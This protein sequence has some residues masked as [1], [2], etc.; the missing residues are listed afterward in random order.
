MH[1]DSNLNEEQKKAVYS[2]SKALLIIAGAGTGKTRVLTTRVAR[3]L[4]ENPEARYLLLTFTK[5]AAKEMTSRVRELIE[6][7]TTNRLYSGTFH[8]FCAN[9]IRRMALRVGLSNNFV[10]IDETDA[11][12]LMKKVFAKIYS[13]EALEALIFKPK[14]ILALY[15]YARNNNQ[16]LSEIIQKRYKYVNFEDIK[17]IISMYETNKKERNYLDFDDLLMYGLLVIKTLDKSPF[18]EVLVDEFQ[19]TNQIQAEMLY[20]FYKLGSRVSAVGD[21]AQSIYS[22]RGAYYENMLNFIKKLDAEKIILSS[23]YRSTQSILDIAN[24]VIQSSYSS[25]KKELVAKVNLKNNVK[26]KLII[27]PDDWE[28]ARYV[29][30]EIQK[31]SEEGLKVAVLYR[32]AYIGRNLESQLNSMGINYSFYGGQKLTESAHAKDFM[33]FLRIFVNIKD[34]IALLRILRMFPG[35]G[36]KKAEKIKDAIIAG[37]NLKDLLTKEKNLTELYHFLSKISGITD[38]HNILEVIFD[39]YKDIMKRL[40]PENY[41]EREIDLVK[42][43]DMSSNYDNLLEYL[44]AFTLDP[45]E[46]SE[47]KSSNIILSTIHSAKGLEFDVVFILSVVEDVYPHFKAQSSDEIEEERRLFYVAITRAKQR[48]IFTFPMYSKKNKSY[49]AKNIISPFLQEKNNYLDVSI[50][51]LN[52]RE[53]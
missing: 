17:K 21:D 2:D 5:K 11:M 19:D 38:W 33:S 41:E 9:I 27:V 28:E 7:D 16:D 45:V 50:V 39:F 52:P 29:A 18:D 1:L 22:F 35:I 25:I 6:E 12:D 37:G 26:P 20:Q 48:L 32:A 15:S 40:Y 8:S 49:F 47:S 53:F 44:E 31:F 43:I 13:K 23:N 30:R 24:S 36:E 4:K 14:D 42:F 3:L 46:K 34:E 10:I 51:K